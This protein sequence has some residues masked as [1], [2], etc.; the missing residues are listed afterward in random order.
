MNNDGRSMIYRSPE[1]IIWAY[2][3][4]R[5]GASGFIAYVNVGRDDWIAIPRAPSTAKTPAEWEF[6]DCAS[7]LAAARTVLVRLALTDHRG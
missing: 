6:P 2:L 4:G 7:A 1:V 3:C 5:E